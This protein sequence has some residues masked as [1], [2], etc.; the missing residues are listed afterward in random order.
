[1]SYFSL[2]LLERLGPA[3]DLWQPNL[4]FHHCK[5]SLALSYDVSSILS[6]QYSV[7]LLQVAAHSLFSTPLLELQQL[8]TLKSI[9]R[10]T[11]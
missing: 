3:P 4:D 9:Q 11:A 5:E 2:D 6:Q 10:R 7:K 1:M 8:N